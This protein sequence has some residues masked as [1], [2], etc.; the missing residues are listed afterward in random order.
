MV[1]LVRRKAD[2]WFPTLLFLEPEQAYQKL[3]HIRTVAEN[4]GRNPDDI[5][6]AYNERC[7]SKRGPSPRKDKSLGVP[8]R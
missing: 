1:D 5:T 7:S 4:A 8:K 6:Y 3:E 2:G